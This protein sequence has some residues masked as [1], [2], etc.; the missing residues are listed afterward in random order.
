MIDAIDDSPATTPP[1]QSENLWTPARIM[2]LSYIVTI[3]AGTAGLMLP[4]ST[5]SNSVA[6]IDALFTATSAVCVTGLAVVN[7]ATFY[8][9]QGQ[10]IILA[11]IQL[12][13]IGILTFTTWILMLT[14]RQMGV[15]ERTAAGSSY[16]YLHGFTWKVI[17]RNVFLFTAAFEGTGAGLLYL[18]WRGTLG[19]RNALFQG[20]FH[21]ISAFCNAGFSTFETGLV[22]YAGDWVLNLVVPSLIIAGGIGFLVLTDIMAWARRR[23]RHRMTLHTRVALR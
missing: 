5:H 9:K 13:G 21:S 1:R 18:R 4:G 15:F 8:T 12:G 14:G 16:G 10:W 6:L 2:F 19:D 7:T 3:A 17:L 11:L 22:D 20:V 23:G